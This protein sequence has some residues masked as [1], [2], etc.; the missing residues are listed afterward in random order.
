MHEAVDLE[1]I[2]IFS[3]A[4]IRA[5]DV[6][7]HQNSIFYALLIEQP[8]AFRRPSGHWPTGPKPVGVK[9]WFDDDDRDNADDEAEE[10]DDDDHRDEDVVTM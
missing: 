8:S 10:D 7:H 3:G 4:D 6:L 5:H 2:C 9:G 1:H